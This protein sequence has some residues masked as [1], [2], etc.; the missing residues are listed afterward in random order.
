MIMYLLTWISPACH[1][2]LLLEGHSRFLNFLLVFGVVP[3][4]AKLILTDFP[5]KPPIIAF[6]RSHMVSR[7]IFLSPKMPMS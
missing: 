3:A 2:D 7:I 6:F 4:V 5:I 1:P